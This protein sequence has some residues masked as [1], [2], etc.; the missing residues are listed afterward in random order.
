M[1]ELTVNDLFPLLLKLWKNKWIIIA[2]TL[3]GFL[4]GMALTAN[5]EANVSYRATSSVCVTYTTYQEQLRGSSVITSY[6]DLVGSYLVCERAA[7]LLEGSGLTAA[8]IQRMV[9]K[10]VASNSYVMYISARADTPQLAIQVANAAAQAFTE[11]VTSVSGNNSIQLLDTAYKAEEI[12][13][14]PLTTV[15]MAAGAPFL[16]ACAWLVIKEIVGGKIRVLAQCA[17]DSEELLG[18]LPDTRQ[19]WS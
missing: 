13:D 3:S 14:S 10:D 15:L 18:I 19:R 9:G 17:E 2:L 1:T 5:D 12:S 11:E 4:G 8:K 6:A 16:L 7:E